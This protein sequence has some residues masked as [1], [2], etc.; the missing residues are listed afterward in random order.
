MKV[1]K[2]VAK[3]ISAYFPEKL[4]TSIAAVGRLDPGGRLIMDDV[5]GEGGLRSAKE[6]DGV[7]FQPLNLG[8]VGQF[9][10]VSSEGTNV[11]EPKHKAE[12]VIRK[13]EKQ[14]AERIALEAA[15][16]KKLAVS[17]AA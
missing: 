13:L 2:L 15:Q 8:W 3:L 1:R 14:A 5:G 7:T 6:L 9:Y 11:L 17:E 10:V 12:Q 16:A 4:T